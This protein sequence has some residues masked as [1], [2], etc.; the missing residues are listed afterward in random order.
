MIPF[1]IATVLLIIFVVGYIIGTFTI[2]TDK[3]LI[4]GIFF[5]TLITLDIGAI[6]G[7]ALLKIFS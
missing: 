5:G 1:I 7:M 6:V 3:A 2:D 4:W